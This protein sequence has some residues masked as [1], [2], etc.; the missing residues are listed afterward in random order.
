VNGS[1]DWVTPRWP[2][3][4]ISPFLYGANKKE[5]QAP[6][7]IE[8]PF[9][10]LTTLR[11]R[12]HEV[13]DAAHLVVKADSKTI[14]DKPFKCGSGVGDWKKAVY[15]DEWK[16]Y[17]NLYDVDVTAEVPAGT[18]KVSLEVQD[19]DWM[20]FGEL[21]FTAQGASPVTLL[22]TMT[23]WGHRP[24]TLYLGPDLL[25]DTT[26]NQDLQDAAWHWKECVEPWKALEAKGVGVMVGEWGVYNKTPHAVMMGFA[27]DVLSNWEK[28]GWG[29]ALWN[30]TGDFG[31][32]DSRREDVVYE[33][34]EGHLLDREM[35]ELL[36]KH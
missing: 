26:R 24:T 30:F 9:P 10:N 4:R 11:L 25:P 7:I 1:Q 16:I 32:L 23:D 36:Q 19:G 22:P 34:W 28:A 33:G 3:L 17:Q 5:F 31:P 6:W 18:Q 35:L 29:W 13:S 20:S 8:G 2:V 12:V 14:L 21:A 27:K 15:R